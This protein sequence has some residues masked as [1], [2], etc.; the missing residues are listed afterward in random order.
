MINDFLMKSKFFKIGLIH[1]YLQNSN[2]NLLFV[3]GVKRSGN[4][5]FIEWLC[6]GLENSLHINHCQIHRKSNFKLFISGNK[7]T[8]YRRS[9]KLN[10][11]EKQIVVDYQNIKPEFNQIAF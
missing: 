11:N 4:H 7:I 10:R 6:A 1:Q 8:W 9:S 3:F 2:L 5:V